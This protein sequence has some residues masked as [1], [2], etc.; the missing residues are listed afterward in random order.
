MAD[1]HIK[2]PHKFNR[3][4]VRNRV[5]KAASDLSQKYGVKSEW[6]GQDHL[7]FSATGVKGGIDIKDSEVE[8]KIELGFLARALKGKIEEGVNKALDRELA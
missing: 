1:I 2:R 8:V 3:E 6:K 7:A 4:D 5:Q